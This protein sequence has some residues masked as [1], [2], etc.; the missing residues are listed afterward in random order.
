M[1]PRRQAHAA[2]HV[3]A[4]DCD[5]AIERV[6]DGGALGLGEGEAEP[7]PVEVEGDVAGRGRRDVKRLLQEAGVPPWQRSR[8]LLVWH[9]DRLVAVLGVATAAG[10]RQSGPVWA[11]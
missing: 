2:H 7:A 1:L 8:Q 10:W 11:T 6:G 3:R 4:F 9:G 5:F